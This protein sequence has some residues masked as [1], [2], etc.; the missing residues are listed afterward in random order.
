M[1]PRFILM[2][3]KTATKIPLGEKV[4]FGEPA[5]IFKVDFFAGITTYA[6]RIVKKLTVAGVNSGILYTVPSGK[7]CFLTFLSLG[8]QNAVA[9]PQDFIIYLNGVDLIDAVT[10]KLAPVTVIF[11]FPLPV[12]LIAGDTI[13]LESF[14]VSSGSQV[15]MIGYEC[16]ASLVPIFL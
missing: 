14:H 10:A 4:R 5:Q 16:D 9:E 8:A 11:P 6:S 7:V 12:K 1:R 2:A 3:G 15:S 13:K